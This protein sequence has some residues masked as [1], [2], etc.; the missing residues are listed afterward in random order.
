MSKR[1]MLVVAVVLMVGMVVGATMAVGQGS[2]DDSLHAALTASGEKPA[3]D[4][5]G[6]G[7]AGVVVDGRRVCLAVAVTD[8]ST[9]AAFHIHKGA[10]GVSGPVVVDP[11]YPGGGNGSALTLGRCVTVDQALASDIKRNP[12]NYYVNVHTSQFAAGAIRGQLS[13]R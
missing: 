6:K 2:S 9:V 4:T 3:G 12:A 13:R 1:L 10:R 7:S 8:L 5:N 11:K